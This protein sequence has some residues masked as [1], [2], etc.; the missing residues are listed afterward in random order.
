MKTKGLSIALLS[1]VL[2]ACGES[3]ERVAERQ[4]AA[5]WLIDYYKRDPIGGGW[6]VRNVSVRE[7]KEVTVAL[8]VPSSEPYS[9]M[10][11]EQRSRVFQVAV[12]GPKEEVWNILPTGDKIGVDV[13]APG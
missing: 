13:S 6:E 10:P 4:K 1:V 7:G 8:S 9:K 12:P 3:P 5:T 2:I 11:F